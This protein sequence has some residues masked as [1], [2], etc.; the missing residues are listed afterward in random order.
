MSINLYI[1]LWGLTLMFLGNPF[2]QGIDLLKGTRT[3]FSRFVGCAK[4]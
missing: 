2:I 1:V 4:R 3:G